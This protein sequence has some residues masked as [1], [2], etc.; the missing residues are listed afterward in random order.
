MLNDDHVV[1]DWQQRGITA[2]MLG[3][4]PHHNPLLQCRP[5]RHG[6]QL[7]A[8]QEKCDAWLFGWSIE[9]ASRN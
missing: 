4:K 3:L 5:S 8:W 1:L 7:N 6:R 2:R 9:D